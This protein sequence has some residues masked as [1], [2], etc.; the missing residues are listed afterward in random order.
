MTI[1][2]DRSDLAAAISG[3]PFNALMTIA[4]ELVDMVDDAGSDRDIKTVVGMAEM[5]AR[6]GRSPRDRRLGRAM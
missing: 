6:L 2:R 4:K 5:L 1:M 3:L